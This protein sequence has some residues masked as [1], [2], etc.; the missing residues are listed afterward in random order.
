MLALVERGHCKP[1]TEMGIESLL[2]HV[3]LPHSTTRWLGWDLVHIWLQMQVLEHVQRVDE[4]VERGRTEVQALPLS[5]QDVSQLHSWHGS[6]KAFS[7]AENE[8]ALNGPQCH[9]PL[10]RA[11]SCQPLCCMPGSLISIQIERGSLVSHILSGAQFL[12]ENLG[13]S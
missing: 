11:L 4:P 10:C 5:S 1:R 8:Y 6:R 12:N 9:H 7:S 13:R 3:H 2:C